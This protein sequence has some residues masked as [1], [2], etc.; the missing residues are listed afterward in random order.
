MTDIAE[1]ARRLLAGEPTGDRVFAA[2]TRDDLA[3]IRATGRDVE[4]A[5]AAALASFD[6]PRA[7]T[8]LAEL[9]D[10]PR[11]EDLFAPARLSRLAILAG[12]S[13]WATHLARDQ[14][15][16]VLDG[17][18]PSA[19]VA[20]ATHLGDAEK[21]GEASGLSPRT[22]KEWRALAQ[23]RAALF[24]LADEGDAWAALIEHT[25]P[26]EIACALA[27]AQAAH[28][29]NERFG[30]PA[31]SADTGFAADTGLTR[32]TNRDRQ[33]AGFTRPVVILG[34]GKL[35]GRELNAS[36][37]IDIVFL[38]GDDETETGH[39][40]SMVEWAGFV[41]RRTS[42]LLGPDGA[43]LRVDLRLRP[44]GQ[45][46]P[47][48][49]S[50]AHAETHYELFGQAWERQMLVRTRPVAGNLSIG[51][52]FVDGI[53]PF[54]YRRHMDP[55]ALA[56][57]R[58]IKRRIDA[59]VLVAAGG[60]ENVK[61]S[62]GGI[63][64]LEYVVQTYQL[65]YGGRLPAL[66]TPGTRE[67]LAQLA[68]NELLPADDLATLTD[69]YLFLRRLENRI[70]MLDG[71][72]N[73]R[74]PAGESTRDA[75]ARSLGLSNGK[76]L[77]LAYD[78]W[79]RRVG[80]IFD[81]LFAQAD[82]ASEDAPAPM[83]EAPVLLVT[84]ARRR[85]E[86]EFAAVG[87]PDPAEAF[88]I[89]A[90]IH[91]EPAT[92]PLPG[93]GALIERLAPK[94]AR[95]AASA[96]DPMGALRGFARFVTSHQA[97]MTTLAMLADDDKMAEVLIRLLGRGS[98]LSDLMLD[99]PEAFV[100]LFVAQDVSGGPVEVE[101]SVVDGAGDGDEAA[102][103]S[104]IRRQKTILELQIALEEM[105]RPDEPEAAWTLIAAMARGVLRALAPLAAAHAGIDA[106]ALGVLLLGSAGGGEPVMNSDIDL[107][108]LCGDA[109][110]VGETTR[111]ARRLLRELESRSGGGRLFRTDVRLRP[112][113]DQGTL[114]ST[115]AAA[116]A[117]Y[118]DAAPVTTR[119]ALLR[120][121]AVC[122]GPARDLVASFDDVL[123]AP[124]LPGA[125]AADLA[126]IRGR[127][128]AET[129]A[130]RLD[131]KTSPG[132]LSD[133]EF[134]IGGLQLRH[135]RDFPAMRGTFAGSAGVP[136][137]SN[138]TRHAI[139]AAAECGLLSK[140][141]GETLTTAVRTLKRIE[142]ALRALYPRPVSLLPAPGHELDMLARMVGEKNGAALVA[143]F[144]ATTERVREIC[145]PRLVS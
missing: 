53:R 15:L 19:F 79:R 128:V 26:A 71:R 70:Q 20:H 133:I 12:S 61:L 51:R 125:R 106:G 5:L 113:G 122:G 29:A 37:D 23:A 31:A 114:V 100:P 99:H 120:A 95:L 134:L 44:G 132:G 56:E 1:I 76:E 39:G 4:A 143:M 73:H 14:L 130:G 50:Q 60:D 107:V 121:T 83:A 111:V 117:F 68:A 46:G 90:K 54:V 8:G 43:G 135:G 129:P 25:A 115:V 64:E 63:R 92:R 27:L 66:R 35:G 36:S 82:G 145:E 116:R 131:A 52:G 7:L 105:Y 96:P 41:A 75:L 13:P 123:F 40:T 16:D 138:A 89:L 21:L 55:R 6:P 94:I 18:P 49:C 74:I 32:D 10:H 141:D 136:P 77:M 110:A 78:G 119:L 84:A 67:A 137:A 144:T 42:D 9:V 38:F 142:S 22:I 102:R 93:L 86:Q 48:A 33:G 57:L 91:D 85:A 45:F 98:Y 28:E 80:E 109:Q 34:M 3:R 124:G 101:R 11:V 69:A 58:R 88:E 81:A 103:L 140:A 24:D 118:R 30:A 47:V 65:L 72:Q 126:H 59:E 62:R 97:P 127:V 17:P 112:H 87:I 139:A 108:F 2:R 104:A